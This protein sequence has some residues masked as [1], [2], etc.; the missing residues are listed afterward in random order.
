MIEALKEA[1]KIINNPEKYTGYTNRE[2]LKKAL[3]S[4]D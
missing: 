4:D 2:E 3:L 1:E